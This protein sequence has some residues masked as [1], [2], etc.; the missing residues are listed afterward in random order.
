M[1]LQHCTLAVVSLS[2]KPRRLDSAETLLRE[3]LKVMHDYDGPFS[4]GGR[5]ATLQKLAQV[6]E[7]RGK[8][9]RHT[10]LEEAMELYT[11]T[12]GKVSLM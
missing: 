6:L 9:E 5:A 1:K 7:S 3:A 10:I 12:Y 8:R 4:V 11:E 2:S